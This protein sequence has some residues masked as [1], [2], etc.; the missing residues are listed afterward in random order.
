MKIINML[1]AVDG[2]ALTQQV[3]DGS[4]SPG[5]PDA[6]TRLGDYS[7]S[8][9]YIIMMASSGPIIDNT[10]KQPELRLG[11]SGTDTTRWAINTLDNNHDQTAYLYRGPF[12]IDVFSTLL[13]SCK[14]KKTYLATG[15]PPVSK[16]T[17]FSNQVSTVTGFMELPTEVM[18]NIVYFTLV[19]NKNGQT[20][21]Y[22]MWEPLISL[23]VIK[24]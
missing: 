14:K 8:G 4:L 24:N 6:P 5:S 22:F 7:D 10:R 2:A 9:V 21:G 13:Y 18:D 17:K 12:D 11:I 3:A 1:I 23:D 15:N 19:N 20:I 16:P